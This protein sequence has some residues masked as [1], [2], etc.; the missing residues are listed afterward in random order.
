MVLKDFVQLGPHILLYTPPDHQVG[1][2]VILCTWMGAADKHIEKYTQIHRQN[3]PGAKI[4]L[5]RSFVGSM[6]SSYKS[7]QRAMKPAADAVCQVLD[8]CGGVQ[9]GG[10]SS[11]KKPRIMLHIMS[12]GGANSATALL[13]V[14]EGRLKTHLPT[15]GTV[16]DSAPNASSYK[17][18]C[19][20]FMY[21]FPYGYPLKIFSTVFIY[22]T[23]TLLYLWIGVGNEP[24][25][26]YWRRSV[27]DDKLLHCRRIC[28]IASKADKIT[29]WNDVVSHA[30]E[31]RN[32]GWATREIIVDDTPHCNHISKHGETY[33]S[34][35]R[36]VWEESKL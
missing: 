9:G 3:A 16:C 4:L 29:D 36:N 5:L 30:E 21:S 1:H 32:K 12:N 25:E 31:A 13:V 8:E 28:Y 18:T 20:A 17:K 6:I 26:D 2:L 7:Q 24:P 22:F 19:N 15:I 34:A 33:V 14:L 23:I 35:V 10:A 11:N 27:L